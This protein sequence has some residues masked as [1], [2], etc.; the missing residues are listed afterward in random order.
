MKKFLPG[1]GGHPIKNDDAMLMQDAY[2]LG[3]QAIAS[4]FD[5]S[6]NII[7]SGVVPTS[8][9]TTVTT[10]AGFVSWQGEVY[11]VAANSFPIVSGGQYFLKF[12][13]NTISPSPTEY[14]DGSIQNVHLDR[15]LIFEYYNPG[16]LG[17]YYVN[18]KRISVSAIPS[19]S[20][21]DWFG[22]VNANFDNTGA[23]INS[24]AG[25][26]ICN[27]VG[28]TPDLRGLF[29]VGA[30]N[31]PSVG[32]PALNPNVGTYN[33]TDAGGNKSNVISKQNLPNYNLTVIDPGHTHSITGSNIT[34]FG[35][36]GAVPGVNFTGSEAGGN[37]NPAT[38]GITVNSGGSG[39]AMENRPPYWCSIKIMK[40]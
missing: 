12:V 24:M 36:F 35:G 18:F 32:A 16:D 13:Q 40:L 11:K 37:T 5:V 23:G 30:T 26:H 1:F 28:G 17:E 7:L 39:T 31:V 34:N 20:I 21:L 27:G 25:Y 9:G 10:T 8:N 33:Q 14:K 19:G 6:Q 2:F 3:F 29:L 4:L 22:N 15:I 38:T